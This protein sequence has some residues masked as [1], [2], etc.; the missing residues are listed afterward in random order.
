MKYFFPVVFFAAALAC[1]SP[2]FAAEPVRE[3]KILTIGNSFS[4]S[5]RTF[6][7]KA[8]AADGVKL[9]LEFAN[10]GGCSFERHWNNFVK[11]EKDPSFKPYIFNRPAKSLQELLTGDKWDIV[12]IQQASPLSWQA[13]SYQPFADELIAAVRKLAPTAEIVIQQT[14]SYN[15]AD[16]RLIPGGRGFWGFDQTGMYEKLDA[17][18][19]GLA[20]KHDLRM[21]PTGYAVQLY[22]KAM[23]D[24][25]VACEPKDCSCTR[26]PDTPK[27]TDVVGS[28][29]WGK[30]GKTGEEKLLR[31]CIHL[32][33]R[34]QYLQ[35]LVWYA[36][37]FG[38]DP[39]KSSF[40]P[41]G[42]SAEEIALLK[43]CAREAVKNYPQV[44][45]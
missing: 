27:T 16:P 30:D 26:K 31:D 43:K 20:R 2:V 29:H 1:A 19:R 10:L 33:V 8:A 38:M 23:G 39:E 25:L 34:G 18:Y 7:A 41:K 17:A 24:K 11:S 4:W 5:L 6:F 35:A 15:A 44:G 42:I 14:W 40:V 32:N 45:R 12:T 21:I 36:E 37:L 3:L 22:R 9:K 28:F 13:E